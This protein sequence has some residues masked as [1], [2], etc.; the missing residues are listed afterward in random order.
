MHGRWFVQR[1]WASKMQLHHPRFAICMLKVSFER[2]DM[3]NYLPP[4][5]VNMT[6]ISQH[7]ANETRLFPFLQLHSKF[8]K[9]TLRHKHSE[10]T[11]HRVFLVHETVSALKTRGRPIMQ[12]GLMSY[13]A[14]SPAQ[15][16]NRKAYP[17]HFLCPRQGNPWLTSNDS[18][19][20]AAAVK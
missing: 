15:I 18:K 13:L 16:G 7:I 9:P 6:K 3:T 11:S 17:A 12:C 1:T 8:P 14:F 10:R 5:A 20:A 4:T 19:K 2:Y